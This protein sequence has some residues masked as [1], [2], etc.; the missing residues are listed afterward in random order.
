MVLS[1]LLKWNKLGDTFRDSPLRP[2]RL[3]G[4]QEVP[5][6]RPVD[7]LKPPPLSS[8]HFRCPA[9]PAAPTEGSSAGSPGGPR[10]EGLR[11]SLGSSP[12]V[13]S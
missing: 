4:M 7:T 2:A 3:L 8:L 13:K 9:D 12:V 11:I 1:S 5:L 10:A 6:S